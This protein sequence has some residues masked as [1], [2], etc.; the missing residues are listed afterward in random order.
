MLYEGPFRDELEELFP[1]DKIVV[2]AVDFACT[3]RACSVYSDVMLDITTDWD[4]DE[5]LR[6]T[7]NPN[8]SG[9]SAK[10]RLSSVDLPTPEG[11]DM[12]RGRTK[13]D[14]MTWQS[15]RGLGGKKQRNGRREM[16]KDRKKKT[17][18]DFVVDGGGCSS[19]VKK[20]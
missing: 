9:Y 20:E 11:P 18:H 3:W 12:S 10:R 8:L 19:T 16:K 14:M 6:E 7:L 4:A 2:F 17:K 15:S 13:C 5:T 1:G